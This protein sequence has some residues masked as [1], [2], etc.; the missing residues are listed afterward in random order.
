MFLCKIRPV[1]NSW[2][3]TVRIKKAEQRVNFAK[4]FKKPAVRICSLA[5]SIILNWGLYTLHSVH[6]PFVLG[7][8]FVTAKTKQSQPVPVRGT[9][10]FWNKEK[11]AENKGLFPL[12]GWEMYWKQK[13]KY[14]S[15]HFKDF[16]NFWI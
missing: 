16:Q 7:T 4:S 5:C 8:Y 9:W 3:N 15:N 10:W 12:L 1:W 6:G 13:K 2:K 14:E 11:K